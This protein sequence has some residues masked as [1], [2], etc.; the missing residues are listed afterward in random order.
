VDQMVNPMRDTVCTLY[1]GRACTLDQM[2]IHAARVHLSSG[3]TANGCA[4]HGS[5][6]AI[7]SSSRAIH[8]SSRAIHS[9]SRAIHARK[10]G[11]GRV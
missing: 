3:C 1:R 8:S 9:S 10:L 5:S 6:R 2:G 7:H 4:I 11:G